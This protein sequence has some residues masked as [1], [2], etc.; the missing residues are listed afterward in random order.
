MPGHELGEIIMHV[1]N[2]CEQSNIRTVD[3]NFLRA[4]VSIT[5]MGEM[6]KEE[7]YEKYEMSEKAVGVN[8]G[9]VELVKRNKMT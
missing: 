4:A 5:L 9:V 7:V 2:A 8:S 1:I 3:M 6:R